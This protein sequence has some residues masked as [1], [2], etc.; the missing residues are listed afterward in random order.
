[1][2]QS[3]TSRVHRSAAVG[4][5]IAIVTMSSAFGVGAT[6]AVADDA[7]T[8]TTPTTSAPAPTADAPSPSPTSDTPAPTTEAPAASPTTDAP[9]E[10][11]APAAAPSSPSSGATSDE[12]VAA[13]AA[14]AGAAAADA[15]AA[16]VAA[17]AVGTVT[18][19]GETTA[20]RTLTADTAG[21]PDGTTFR[22]QWTS[23]TGT[24]T[25]PVDGATAATYVVDPQDAGS[26]LAVVVTATAPGAAAETVTSTPSAVVA[27]DDSRFREGGGR[28]FA[29]RAGDDVSIDLRAFDGDQGGLT[30]A[31]STI[32]P[33]VGSIAGV[34]DGLTVTEGGFL[35][36][37]PT[38]A[39]P[40]EFVINAVTTRH[41]GG[42]GMVVNVAVS[43]GV[44]KQ[45]TVIATA[46]PDSLYPLWQ[47]DPDGT[48]RYTEST[49]V[50][51]GDPAEPLR[52]RADQTLSLYTIAYDAYDNPLVDGSV[53]WTSSVAGDTFTG[54]PGL[55]PTAVALRFAH[56][57]PHVV[58][59]AI[60][61]A[62][63][64]FTVQVDPVSSSTVVTPTTPRTTTGQ[65]AYT[66]ADETGP[67]AWALGL[68]GAGVGAA[69]LAR[70]IR[71]RRI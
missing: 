25:S 50:Q 69:M 30:Y 47:I 6:A 5:A 4:T 42:I 55:S 40:W 71:R 7:P 53:S 66:G 68:L 36:G 20:W 57:S 67:I 23:T 51:V 26:T 61:D 58:T 56:A 27:A 16:D 43:P 33:P 22:Y 28:D 8:S 70:R 14:A 13:D 18:V 63:T 45:A 2:H 35:V 44:A 1:M 62:R 34:P 37:T 3:C 38:R 54:G 19:S 9:A 24:T 49:E 39:V 59:V 11:P 12:G 46:D 29:M 10:T 48:T 17:A 41:P 21:Y 60:G 32:T 52:V 64:T 15:S 65:L 31:A